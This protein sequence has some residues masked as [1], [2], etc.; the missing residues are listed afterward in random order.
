MGCHALAGS[1]I[2]SPSLAAWSPLLVLAPLAA[3]RAQPMWQ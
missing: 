1:D 2:L 3:W